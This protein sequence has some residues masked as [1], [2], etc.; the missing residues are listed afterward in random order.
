MGILGNRWRCFRVFFLLVLFKVK[1]IIL[2][3]FIFY[4]WLRVD[5][6]SRNIYSLFVFIDREDFEIVEVIFGLWREDILIG[7]FFNL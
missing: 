3:V 5:V 4:N 7:F 6:S 1:G 2:V